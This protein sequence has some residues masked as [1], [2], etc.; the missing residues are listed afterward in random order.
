M[1][2]NELSLRELYTTLGQRLE[3][4]SLPELQ[5][6]V[7]AHAAEVP[8]DERRTFL[9]FF[10][11]PGN[12]S[13]GNIPWVQIPEVVRDL[14]WPVDSDPLLTDI[15][16][17]AHRVETG[18]FFEGL[19]WDDEILDERSFGDDS[20]T[21]EME[22]YFREA[23]EAFT[24]GRLGL[25]RTA[26]RKLFDTLDLDD[27]VGTF[28]GQDTAVT[29]L[30]TNLQ[31]AISQ[32][33]RA[34][35]ETSTPEER[36]GTLVRK[37]VRL[38]LP[39]EEPSLQDIRD[40]APEDVPGFDEF[41]PVW[42]RQLSDGDRGNKVVRALLLEA[43]GLSGGLGDL[44]ELARRPGPGQSSLYLEWI[45][46]LRSNGATTQAA[47]VAREAL[48]IPAVGSYNRAA[49]AEELA[50]LSASD[51]GAV[52]DARRVAWRSRPSQTRLLVLHHAAAKLGDPDLVMAEEL[53]Y[54][55]ANRESEP[56]VLPFFSCLLL[57]SG[58]LQRVTDL[59]SLPPA[60]REHPVSS[61]V[62]VPYLLVSASNAFAGGQETAHWAHKYL[63][64]VDRGTPMFWRTGEPG[65]EGIPQ[66]SE[67]FASRI[68]AETADPAA[69][70][71]RLEAALAQLGREVDAIV[72]N[73]RRDEYQKAAEWLADGA[74]AL[75]LAHG[76]EAG[77]PWFRDW[78]A[79]Y[80]RHVAF[81]KELERAWPGAASTK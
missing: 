55:E 45:Q 6:A 2:G 9:D 57:L 26:Y 19:G 30:D 74:L 51:A 52:F 17:F 66:L 53:A 44:G 68:R 77:V 28:S 37:W 10:R 47:E 49:I 25:A 80:P 56:L 69:V 23:H 65:Q 60:E 61:S 5:R 63:K 41:L 7:L 81:R 8:A 70:E 13:E 64:N 42:F 71:S 50:E 18:H 21:G 40:C 31:E 36:A 12:D 14:T 62:M 29:M 34:V 75:S 22:E 78:S 73:K 38:P 39:G 43:A 79:R 32:Y 67:L 54:L 1:N 3:Q 59:L 72:S 48:S 20:W 35:Y 4:L 24:T 27:E 46:A 33:L 76:G 15:D 16:D 58:E 11:S